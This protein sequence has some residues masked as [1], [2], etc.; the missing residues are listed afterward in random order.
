MELSRRDLLKLCGASAAV[1][2]V[3][4]TVPPST[5]TPKN[6]PRKSRR[7]RQPAF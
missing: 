3:G 6:R 5:L 2:G 4:A 7:A 1:L